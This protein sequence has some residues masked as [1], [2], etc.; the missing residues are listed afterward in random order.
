MPVG[1]ALA[2]SVT[3]CTRLLINI[4]RAYYIG[5]SRMRLNDTSGMVIHSS[6][7]NTV[8]T[9]TTLASLRWA[10][11]ETSI[12]SESIRTDTMLDEDADTSETHYEKSEPSD[13]QYELK[14]LQ[15]GDTLDP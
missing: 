7:L 2:F 15:C 11:G 8:N 1:F 3:N 9:V 14:T 5:P 6:D 4:R 13:S 12:G 10:H